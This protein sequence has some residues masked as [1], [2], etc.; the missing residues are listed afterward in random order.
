MTQ[1]L[2]I[3]IPDDLINILDSL[4]ATWRTTRSGVF[5]KLLREVEKDRL[6]EKMAEG[7]K[8]M[9]ETDVEIYLP[10]QAEV[11]LNDKTRS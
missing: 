10:A 11:V 6:E 7:Y 3:S 4:T 5:A 9:S 8:A 1:K 2:T